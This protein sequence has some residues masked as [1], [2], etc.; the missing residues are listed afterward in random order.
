V[1][2]LFC[3]VAKKSNH[4]IK[5]IFTTSLLS[6][7]IAFVS[8]SDESLTPAEDVSTSRLNHDGVISSTQSSVVP[9]TYESLNNGTV[10][11]SFQNLSGNP[12][13]GDVIRE[14]VSYQQNGTILTTFTVADGASHT[15]IDDNVMPG[16]TYRYIF[17]YIIEGTNEYQINFDTVS[18]VSSV[19]AL[20]NFL[21]LPPDGGEAYDFLFNGQT[22]EIGQTNILVE[23]DH[24]LTHSVVFNLNGTT[25]VDNN[26]PFT[27]FPEGTANLQNGSYTLTAIAYPKKK[28]KGVAGDTTTVS[29]TVN[30]LY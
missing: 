8:C 12:I 1:A 3:P 7:A 30:N 19:P 26:S 6:I 2:L 28:G 27:L 18:V 9:Y 22:I 23:T 24:D 4:M 20:G 11:L 15:F 17:E 21:L 10:K 25:Y 29:F 16:E 5:T 14:G 13:E